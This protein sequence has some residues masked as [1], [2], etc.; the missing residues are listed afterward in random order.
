MIFAIREDGEVR[1]FEREEELLREWGPYARDVESGVVAFYAEDGTWLTPIL[2]KESRSGSES[3]Q[4]VSGA[5][6]V[7]M[8]GD[9]LDLA[10]HEAT[11]LVPNRH[12]GTLV[13]LRA[14][15]PFN[16]AAGRT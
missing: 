3:F 6:N 11:M 15:F 4:L 1:V 8:R 16:V 13:E 9:P 12:F 10:L 14:R 2:A 7:T 5:V